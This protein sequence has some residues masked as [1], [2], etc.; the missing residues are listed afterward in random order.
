MSSEL[1]RG[2]GERILLVDDKKNLLDAAGQLLAGI[3][4]RLDAFRD[5]VEALEAFKAAPMDFELL[6]SDRSMPNFTGI[7]LLQEA[8]K[9]N[10]QL[11]ASICTGYSELSN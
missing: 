10:A 5:P 8:R 7:Q 11:P 6:I 4:Y 9:F 2:N 3:G 1:I